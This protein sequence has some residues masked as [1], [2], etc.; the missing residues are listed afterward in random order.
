MTLEFII[1]VFADALYYTC[2]ILLCTIG[3]LFAYKAGIVNIGLEGMMLFGGFIGAI[4]LFFTKSWILAALATVVLGIL[5]G[6]LF[7][8]FGVS[9]K[10]NFIITGFAINLLATAVGRYA[11]AMMNTTAI[12]VVGILPNKLVN[13][14]LGFI[15]KIPFL[16][17][18]LSGQTFLTYLSFV[19]IIVAHFVLYKTKFGTYVRVVGESEESA[20]SVGI[21]IN[22]IKYLAI[23]IG[24]LLCALAGYNVAVNNIL[25]Y[26]PDITAGIGF[27][28]IAAIYCG[29]GNPKQSSL[30]AIIFGVS[31]SLAVNLALRVGAVA[32]LLEIIPYVM[33][34]VVLLV[35]GLFRKRKT[36]YRGFLHE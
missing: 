20:T 36:L 4:V 6:I 10:A 11:L 2:P 21:K 31:R 25:S 19:L 18:I 24:G 34:V 5:I 16:G 9:K 30:Y 7:S 15:G 29:N 1:K 28:A 13:I 35:V 17:P 26:T 23:I 8:F 27:I 32:G 12:N 22:F 14:D 3:G 33:I